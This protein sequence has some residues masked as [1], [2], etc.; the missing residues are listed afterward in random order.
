MQNN[1]YKIAN[2]TLDWNEHEKRIIGH[3]MET[4]RR[5]VSSEAKV[6]RLISTQLEGVADNQVC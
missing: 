6:A 5:T 2:V 4:W 3:A 1:F